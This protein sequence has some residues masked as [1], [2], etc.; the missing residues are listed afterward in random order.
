MTG[1]CL[2]AGSLH[3]KTYGLVALTGQMQGQ[4][5]RNGIMLPFQL[6]KSSVT[7]QQQMKGPLLSEYKNPTF[8]FIALKPVSNVYPL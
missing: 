7:T 2:I 5:E 8:I 1:G 3:V 6:G 4:R